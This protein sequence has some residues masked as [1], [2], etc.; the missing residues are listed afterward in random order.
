M[1]E[2]ATSEQQIARL[3]SACGDVRFAVSQAGTTRALSRLD[4]EIGTTYTML[5][6]GLAYLDKHPDDDP[7]TDR[8][9]TL[10]RAYE[11]ACTVRR[12]EQ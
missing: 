1:S 8:W 11:Q 10:L 7:N 9:I 3:R 6:Q 2:R 5:D 12:E 4:K